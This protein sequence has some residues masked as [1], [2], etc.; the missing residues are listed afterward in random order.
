[1]TD[2]ES[3]IDGPRAACM[4]ARRA[5]VA[6]RRVYL[7]T[8]YSASEHACVTPKLLISPAGAPLGGG[9][10]RCL[11]LQDIGVTGQAFQYDPRAQLAPASQPAAAVTR[12]LHSINL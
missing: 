4:C 5:L 10:G 8:W 7:I 6:V 3:L 11:L 12:P 1:M 2:S 9:W